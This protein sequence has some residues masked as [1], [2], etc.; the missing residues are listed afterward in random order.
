MLGTLQPACGICLFACLSLSRKARDFVCCFYLL[1]HMPFHQMVMHQSSVL[2]WPLA[3]SV[4][5]PAHVHAYMIVVWCAMMVQH[6]LR[7][8]EVVV[9]S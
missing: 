1:L 8:V 2:N 7:A 5:R 4:G 3:V 9:G 6:A